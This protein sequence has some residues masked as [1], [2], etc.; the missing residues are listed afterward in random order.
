MR[1]SAM[2]IESHSST[3]LLPSLTQF[4]RI[5]EP[6]IASDQTRG[7][8]LLCTIVFHAFELISSLYLG[9]GNR[10]VLARGSQGTEDVPGLEHRF[11]QAP[12]GRRNRFFQHHFHALQQQSALD[13]KTVVVRIR[14]A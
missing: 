10:A 8:C 9:L 14:N 2:P 7:V 4:D 5:S 12:V 3:A 11:A 13:Q 6:R 1:T